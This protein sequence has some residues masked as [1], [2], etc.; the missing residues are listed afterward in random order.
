MGTIDG[1][2]PEGAQVAPD[3]KKRTRPNSYRKRIVLP[4]VEPLNGLT[5][6]ETGLVQRYERMWERRDTALSQIEARLNH[7]ATTAQRRPTRDRPWP[8]DDTLVDMLEK[9][10]ARA[11]EGALQKNPATAEYLDKFDAERR[12]RRAEEVKQSLEPVR[13]N[14]DALNHLWETE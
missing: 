3:N 6:T 2:K 8:L 13:Q 9:Q 11:R 14:N 10:I 4:T 12:A 5:A 7:Q 1:P